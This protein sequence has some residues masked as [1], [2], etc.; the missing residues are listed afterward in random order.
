[1]KIKIYF[2]VL[3]VLPYLFYSCSQSGNKNEEEI[4]VKVESNI[5]DM[6]EFHFRIDSI[7]EK[8]NFRLELKPNKDFKYPVD[9]KS[10]DT[11]YFTSFKLL[12]Y[13][14]NKKLPAPTSSLLESGK[15]GVKI[16]I[17]ELGFKIDTIYFYQKN[18]IDIEFS[19]PFLA[20][21][22]IPSG[23]DREVQLK[24][25]QEGFYSDKHWYYKKFDEDTFEVFYRNK[26]KSDSRQIKLSFKLNIPKIYTG[27]LICSRIKLQEDTE[28]ERSDGTLLEGYPDMFFEIYNQYHDVVYKSAIHGETFD[29]TKGNTSEF[30]FFSENDTI[31]LAVMDYDNWSS[32]DRI[33]RWRGPIK[34]LKDTTLKFDGVSAFKI[35]LENIKLRN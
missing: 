19:V 26:T 28:R 16:L 34:I 18:G 35:K 25:I 21:K 4:E 6:A 30:S 24:I 20:F 1:M 15:I 14:G 33:S 13:Y 12:F 17:N 22:D 7:E 3:V 23:P 32:S 31:T 2:L 27:D 10:G 11:L 5:E 29:W 9:K 8:I